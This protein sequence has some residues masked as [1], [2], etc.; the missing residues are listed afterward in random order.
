MNMGKY[1]PQIKRVIVILMPVFIFWLAVNSFLWAFNW[2][3]LSRS[4]FIEIL[5]TPFGL[6]YIFVAM[7]CEFFVQPFT[8][9]F[10]NF[11]VKSLLYTLVSLAVAFVPVLITIYRWY[12]KQSYENAVT[13][14]FAWVFCG[15]VLIIGVA[16]SGGR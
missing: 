13:N 5:L 15:I 8:S 16:L 14:F 7:L 9:G 2:I 6:A 1:K 4:S 11:W 3:R 12:R 10:S